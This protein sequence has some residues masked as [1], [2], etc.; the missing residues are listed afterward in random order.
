MR[1][2]PNFAVHLDAFLQGLLSI[3]YMIQ[4]PWKT[5]P[6]I[7]TIRVVVRFILPDGRAYEADK[8]LKV[9]LMP[10]AALRSESIPAETPN[11]RPTSAGSPFAAAAVQQAG[12]WTPSTPPNPV[13]SKSQWQPQPLQDAVQL[14]RPLPVFV[15][16][17][18]GFYRPVIGAIRVDD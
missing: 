12:L 6:R 3:G 14:G 8:D 17:S 7:E 16:P 10:G 11:F 1:P 18:G 15:P 9:R 2:G 13:Q 4:L 5:P